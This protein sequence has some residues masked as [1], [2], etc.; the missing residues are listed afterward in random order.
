MMIELLLGAVLLVAV[1]ALVLQVFGA[2]RRVEVDL[3]SLEGALNA[4]VAQALDR[5]ER[6]VRDEVARNRDE[7][8]RASR[9]LREEL[10]GAVKGL[11]DTLAQQASD[12]SKRQQQQLGELGGHVARLAEANE[13]KLEALR[14]AVLKQ[15]EG[16]QETASREA[17][18]GR[19]E[20][21]TSGKALRE[22]VVAG[23]NALGA[24]LTAS[25]SKLGEAQERQLQEFSGRL[26]VLTAGTDQKLGA[27]R[28]TIDAKM[29][30]FQE[31]NSFAASEARAQT[32]ADLRGAREELSLSFKAFSENVTNAMTNIASLQKAQLE[33]FAN[34][35]T[36]LTQSNDTRLNQVREAVE[37]RLAAV[38][39]DGGK[40]LDQMRAEAADAAA[41]AREQVSKAL[42][43]FHDGVAARIGDLTTLQ[44]TRLGQVENQLLTLTQ[45]NEQRLD[46][47]RVVVDDRLRLVQEDSGKKLDQMRDE[48][49][50]S[51]RQLR[52]ELNAAFK[53]ANDTVVQTMSAM[54]DGQKQEMDLLGT[55]L[56]KLTASN[57]AKLEALRVTVEEKLRQLQEDNANRL[58]QMRATVDEKLQGTLEK[59]LGESFALVSERL[60]QVHKG[61]GEMQTLAS[62][63]G[64]LKRVMTNVKTRGGWGEVQL[65]AILEQI[66]SPAQYERNV[67]TRE[68]SGEVV[69]FAIK[70]P[71]RGDE[72]SD[73]V[74][75]PIDAKFPKEDYERLVEAQ[76]NADLEG[77]EAAG[78]A[79]ESRVRGCA[80][81]IAVKYLNPPKTTDFGIMFLPTEGLYAEVIRRVGLVDRIQNESRVVIAGP[82][83][84]T[85]ILSSL[86]MGFR[87]LAIQKRSSEVWKILGAVKTE[88]G[89]FGDLLDGVKKKLDAASN[90]ID[91][92]TSKSR[93]IERK[94]K[95][96]E[97]LP[98]ADAQALLLAD[99]EMT[100]EDAKRDAPSPA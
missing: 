40:R 58:E 61:L 20:A 36:T 93:N 16:A 3:S 73:V 39:D 74:W 9:E 79:L 25:L 69:E 85:A 88:F 18:R 43:D 76:E 26:D 86:Q 82:T 65:E 48:S 19:D 95:A 81:D 91:E 78:K 98:A 56:G 63:V 21:A 49:A 77:V 87:T 50:T 14:E 90:K 64:D 55:Q 38:Q 47:L 28:D 23:V 42:G 59:R 46:N 70:L 51:T 96:V 100:V 29:R 32:A 2:R 53:A 5:T 31:A 27:M 30:A 4:H 1:A 7:S 80:K 15:L 60:E 12:A 75:L 13:S 84:L 99:G 41:K 66:L 97:A 45:S 68:G 22:E 6:A 52:E 17:S 44:S 62:S 33:T 11:G 34:Q 54:R 83:T 71:G 57:E 72:A 24:S 8:L 35:L 37:Q 89:K 94:L 10:A 92:A 67:S